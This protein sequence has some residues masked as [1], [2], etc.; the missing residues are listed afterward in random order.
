MQ[1]VKPEHLPEVH[2]R[3]VFPFK[4]SR[5]SSPAVS[6]MSTPG[7]SRTREF[8]ASQAGKRP[9]VLTTH[10]VEYIAEPGPSVHPDRRSRS[11]TSSAGIDTVSLRQSQADHNRTHSRHLYKAAHEYGHH[12]VAN[13]M[14]PFLAHYRIPK[15]STSS[16]M[17]G[18]HYKHPEQ[19]YTRPIKH[20][21]PVFHVNL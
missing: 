10:G 12:E 17:Y 5:P 13:N 3:R 21:M 4:P 14:N 20:R 16:G 6:R 7:V 2:E 1:H 19:T 9:Y 8:H 11:L 15:W 18:E